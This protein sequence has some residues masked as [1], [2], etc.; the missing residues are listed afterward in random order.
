MTSIERLELEL[1]GSELRSSL[2]VGPGLLAQAGDLLREELGRSV[3]DR[4]HLVVDRGPG[5]VVATTHA[6]VLEAAVRGEGGVSMGLVR[7]GESEKSI[8]TVVEQWEALAGAGVDRRGIVVGLG[9]G[10]VCDLAGF[11]A[12]TWMRGV[13]LVL[14]P[15]TLL[16]MV[17]AGLG[18]KTGI[19]RPLPGGG[20]GKNLVGSFWPA[21]LVLC[22]TETLATLGERE[23]RS[24]LAECVKH[25]IIEGEETLA[26]LE[27]DLPSVLGRDPEALPR[28]VARSAGVKAG[29]VARDFREGGERA[30]LNLGHTYAHAIESRTEFGL[31]HGEA[32]SIG[33]VAAAA[34]SEAGGF[35]PR[36]LES[37]IRAM[38]Q[39][40]GLPTSLPSMAG[41][42][43][44][45]L[46][47]AMQLDKKTA[48]GRLRLV[49]PFGMG[50]CR[51][52]ADPD[53]Q[54]VQAGWDAVAPAAA[55]DG[56]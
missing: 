49:L 7:A 12:A 28:F 37:R 21:R 46:R 38:L 39:A 41:G 26:A 43:L 16:S 22:D 54:V 51:I 3:G 33:L 17:D 13:R 50:D 45:V 27:A 9:G 19:N 1:P 25:G 5:D 4:V 6:P 32:V 55:R 18:G 34:A 15:T 44:P 11:V 23:F 20:L 36:G 24:G 30:L 2:V 52:V 48:A 10:I 40:C 14:A 47:Q 35:G 42:L 29:V 56:S 8:A 53:E 31:L